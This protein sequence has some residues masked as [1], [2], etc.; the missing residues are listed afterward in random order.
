MRRNAP[1]SDGG[2]KPEREDTA[3]ATFWDIDDIQFHCRVGRTT[4]WKLVKRPDFPDPVVVGPH[5]LVW[6]RAEGVAFMDTRRSPSH[7]GRRHD[8]PAVPADAFVSRPV[9]V[10]GS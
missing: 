3:G 1:R 5:G 6:P 4:A 2:A 8:V 9:A 7:Y 10:R